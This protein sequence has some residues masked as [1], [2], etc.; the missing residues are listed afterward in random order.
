MSF[1]QSQT[2][3]RAVSLN[4]PNSEEEKQPNPVAIKDSTIVKQ[5]Q[6]TV[7]FAVEEKPEKDEM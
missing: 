4:E 7:R 3:Y 1:T 2:P 5:K 6:R